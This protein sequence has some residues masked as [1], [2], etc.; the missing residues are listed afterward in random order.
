MR[1]IRPRFSRLAAG[2]VMTACAV[3]VLAIGQSASAAGHGHA[4]SAASQIKAA[5]LAIAPFEKTPTSIGETQPLTKPVKGKVFDFINDGTPF[6][7]ALEVGVKQAVTALG[8][9]LQ[10]VSQQ[11]DA[12]QAVQAAWNQV[13]AHPPAVVLSGGDP[14][15]LYQTQLKTLRSKHIPVVAFFTNEDPLLAANIYGPPQYKEL[16]KLEAD[17]IIAKSHGKANVLVVEVPQ[18]SG[19]QGDAAALLAN[20]KSGCSGCAEGSIDTQLQDIGKN[21]PA[22]IVSYM[23][24]NPST[25]WIVYVDADTEIGVPE[26]LGGAGI[27]NVSMLTGAGGKVN[28]AYIKA[29]LSTVDA[30][31]PASF[32]GWALVDAAARVLDHQKVRVSFF[33]ME[34]LTKST[35]TFNINNPWPDV[36]HYQKKFEALWGVSK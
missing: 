6:E 23:Q 5:Q 21:D 26:A 4:A 35:L 13:V 25:N 29:G 32:S 31:Q 17:Y 10:V 19:L 9:K 27:H 36:P 7:E 3:S 18:I 14:T 30:S 33:P 11:G 20:L 12:P 24:K 34:F 28:Y 22:N 8:D 16:G 15:A 1:G 2:A